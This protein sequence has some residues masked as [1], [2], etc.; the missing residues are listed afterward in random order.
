MSMDAKPSPSSA[1]PT[2]TIHREKGMKIFVW[3]KVIFLYPT[4][5]VALLCWAGMWVNHDRTHDPTRSLKDAV[6]AVA[7]QGT[8]IERR[9]ARRG[10]DPSFQDAARRRHHCHAHADN[11]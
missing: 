8:V 5:I 3:P 10:E 4:A 11:F 9:A 1:A 7:I 6:K 2:R